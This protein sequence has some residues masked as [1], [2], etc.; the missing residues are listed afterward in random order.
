MRTDDLIRALAQDG[1]KGRPPGRALSMALVASLPV[2]LLLFL[3]ILGPRPDFATA[4]ENLRFPLKFVLT[5]ALAVPALALAAVLARPGAA[6]RG[7]ARWLLLAPALLLVAVAVELAVTPAAEWSARWIGHNWLVCLGAIPLLSLAP[8]AGLLIALR[9]GAPTRPGL[10]G[11]VAGLAAGALG[12]T[13][14]A[15]HCPDDSPLFVATWYVVAI[16]LVTI[17]GAALGSRLLRW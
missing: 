5:L 16:G 6:W 14:Y 3:V 13:F 8:L 9:D 4:L 2:A 7:R 17:A 15:A 1:Q 12:A 10:A 11:A